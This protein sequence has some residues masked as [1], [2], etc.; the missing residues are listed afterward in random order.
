[1]LVSL[2]LHATDL[3]DAVDGFTV[4][5]R[6]SVFPTFKFNVVADSDTP[7]AL[8]LT[9]IVTLAVRFPSRVATVIIV[10]PFARAVITPVE[11]TD[12]TIGL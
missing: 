8:V 10:V 2:V 5:R 3:L 7:V 6:V 4:A 11:E 1:M 12:A 9:V